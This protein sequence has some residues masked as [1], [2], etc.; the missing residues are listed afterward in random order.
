MNNSG[1]APERGAVL[2]FVAV[3]QFLITQVTASF[4]EA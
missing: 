4:E 3:S 2:R 1:V